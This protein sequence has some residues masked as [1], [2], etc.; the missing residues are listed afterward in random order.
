M[1]SFNSFRA[2]GDLCRLLIS[3]VNSMDPDQA[4]LDPPNMAFGSCSVKNVEEK[5][6]FEKKSAAD[7]ESMHAKSI[8]NIRT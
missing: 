4:D 7:N 3:F 8:L 1:I 6:D 2:S 5:V